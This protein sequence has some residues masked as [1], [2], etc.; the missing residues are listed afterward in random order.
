[1]QNEAHC[2]K[3]V[4]SYIYYVKWYQNDWWLG[5]YDYIKAYK[6]R[7]IQATL[8]DLKFNTINNP[9]Q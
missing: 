6:A 4:C 9:T 2:D 1:M 7:L 8:N 3:Y 5:L